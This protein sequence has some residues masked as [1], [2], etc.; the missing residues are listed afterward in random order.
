MKQLLIITAALIV[1][2]CQSNQKQTTAI[3]YPTAKTVDSADVFYGIKVPDPYRWLEDYSSPATKEWIKAENEVT[4]N[5]LEKIPFRENIKKELTS[6]INYSRMTNPEK[7]GDY[8]Y[9]GKNSGLQNQNV[10]Y[11][12]KNLADTSSAEIFLDPNTFANLR[13]VSLQGTSFTND[14]TLM[15]SLISNG[16]S[17]WRDILVKKIGRASCRESV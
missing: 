14:G 1:A 16:G 13:T 8:Y 10:L 6:L 11:R 7:H 4:D 15:A 12:T 5:Y 3:T 17:D 9:F 2:G